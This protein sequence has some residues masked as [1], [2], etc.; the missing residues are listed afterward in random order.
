VPELP[1][2]ETVVRSIRPH[3]VGRLIRE[4]HFSSR[5]VTRTSF[6]KNASKL[7]GRVI[8][9]I[10][11]HG[12]HMLAQLDRGY[13]HIHLGMTG[14]LLWNGT[15]GAHTRA[16][17]ELDGGVLTYDD[18]RQFGRVEYYG[19]VPEAIQRLGPDPLTISLA[20]FHA[21][22]VEHRSAIKPLLL[23]Q[24]FLAGL[25]NIYTDEALFAARIHP[26]TRSQRISKKRAAELY[27]AIQQV[28]GAAVQHRGSS[29][30]D[31]VDGVGERGG[32]QHLHQVYGKAGEP[33][34]R[35]GA[36]IRRVVV[37]QRGTHLCPRCQ[38]V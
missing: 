10:E 34:P 8:K 21:R 38:K 26:R 17:L 20:E 25:G 15:P 35:C 5:F 7:R 30:S 18:T 23:N 24:S 11:R 14:Q 36:A 37:A 12:K 9:S 1:E 4:A 31:Y 22:L 13:L 2:V 33:C 29:I 3:I 16:I 28:L 32:F 19:E 6:E 27:G